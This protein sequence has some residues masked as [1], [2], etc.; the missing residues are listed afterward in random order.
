MTKESKK[1]LIVEDDSAIAD[2]YK[3]IVKK[4][5]FYVEIVKSGR[6]AIDKIKQAADEEKVKPD[7]VILD[8]VSP[9]MNGI[10]VLKKIRQNQA[11]KD[12]KVFIFSNQQKETQPLLND[13][14]TEEFFIKANTT[15]NQL[16]EIIKESLK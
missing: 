13:F 6:E 5:N 11:T 9:D 1:V 15:P 7:V 16:I 8:L 2:I 12:T 14:A 4:E 10:E 3:T